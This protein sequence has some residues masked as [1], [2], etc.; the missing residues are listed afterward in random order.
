MNTGTVSEAAM[1]R[2][3]M[4]RWMS[5][6]DTFCCWSD[7]TMQ[8]SGRRRTWSM[9]ALVKRPAS[10]NEACAEASKRRQTGRRSRAASSGGRSVMRPLQANCVW[11]WPTISGTP[12]T[13]LW[14]SPISLPNAAHMRPCVYSDR[15]VTP[16]KLHCE[17]FFELVESEI[18]LIVLQKCSVT[19]MRRNG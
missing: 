1:K 4:I 9:Q 7:A 11:R 13:L 17:L 8:S 2:S 16:L 10:C 3:V 6:R 5:Y 18:G 12:D 14:S 19:R 15:W